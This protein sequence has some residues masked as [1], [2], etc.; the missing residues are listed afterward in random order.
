MKSRNEILKLK[1]KI[2]KYPTIV[3][4]KDQ[5]ENGRNQGNLR[6]LKLPYRFLFFLF[7]ATIIHVKTKCD[8]R[9]SSHL[10]Y[11]AAY[12]EN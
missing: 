5:G 8:K 1:I 6:G 3:F 7:M 2:K 9:K 11:I 12:I 10:A 4:W